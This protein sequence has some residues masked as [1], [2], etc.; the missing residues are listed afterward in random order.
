MLSCFS[1]VQLFAIRWPVAHQA[2][3]SM[4]FS[5]QEYQSGLPR[6]PPGIFPTQ[7][8]NPRLWPLLHWQTASLPLVPPGKLALRLKNNTLNLKIPLL[9]KWHQQACST[10]GCHKLPMFWNFLDVFFNTYLQSATRRST[11][12]QGLPGLHFFIETFKRLFGINHY[13]R[14]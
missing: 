4:G 8:W 9:G 14:L 5:R 11:I 6:P 3:L 2:P 12:K 13:A 1:C 10:E 7:G